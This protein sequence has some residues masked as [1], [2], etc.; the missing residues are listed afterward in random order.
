MPILTLKMHHTASG[1]IFVALFALVSSLIAGLPL[2]AQWNISPLIIGVVLG[3]VYANTFR[4][5][6]PA[7]WNPGIVFSTKQILRL[8]VML[9]GFHITFQQIVAVGG[10]GLLA[11]FIILVSTLLLGVVAGQRLLKLD[12]HT[13]LLT[14]MGASICG[15]AAVLATEPTIRAKPHQATIAVATVVLFGTLAMFLYPIVYSTGIL[16]FDAQTYGIYTGATVHEVAQVVA[17]GKAVS[18]SAAETAV[19]VKMGRVLMLAPLLLIMGAWIAWRAQHP[20]E[21]EVAKHK[22]PIPWF[23]FGFIVFAGINSLQFLPEG[24]VTQINRLDTFLL[25][26]AMCAL[27]METSFKKIKAV[28]VKPFY[29]GLILFLWLSV[30]GYWIVRGVLS[31]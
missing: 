29:L 9:Y 15:A 16:H 27:G 10:A 28:G 12:G 25:T 2:V 8:A 6:L 1:V 18:E 21:G 20:A 17:A 3:M 24:L 19:I 26:M 14:A 31:F 5:S 13:S 7:Q 11:S 22:V 4:D 23:A 30:G